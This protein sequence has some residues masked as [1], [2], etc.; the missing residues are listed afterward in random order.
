[1]QNKKIRNATP[2]TYEGVKY[3]SKLE[4]KFAKILTE[5]GVQFKYE[6]PTYELLP[7]QEFQGETLR[8]VTYTPDFFVKDFIIEVKGFKNDVYPLK[9]KLIANFLNKHFPAQ[10]FIEIHNE[11]DMRAALQSI[12]NEQ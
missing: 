2:T 1:M 9:K 10:K 6:F 8:P 7:R 11:R 3:R 4:A 12:L 5:A